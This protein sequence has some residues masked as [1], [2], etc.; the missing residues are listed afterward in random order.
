MLVCIP[1]FKT[2]RKTTDNSIV[3]HL[4]LA[5]NILVLDKDGKVIEQ[6]TYEYLKSTTGFVSQLVLHP[7]LLKP[8][9]IVFEDVSAARPNSASIPKILEGPSAN[10]AAD[11]ARRTGD[12]SIYKYYIKSIGLK[13][14][15]I[16][17]GVTVA[18]NLANRSPRK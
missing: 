15:L 10:D 14:G 4:P 3:R 11:L 12:I 6:G 18:Y 13:Y 9:P 1:G 5:D 7:E 17:F 16:C 2:P 8:E